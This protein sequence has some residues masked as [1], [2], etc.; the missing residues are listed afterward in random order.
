MRSNKAN[1][2][3]ALQQVI[4]HEI[5]IWY[6]SIAPGTVT[7]LADNRLLWMQGWIPIHWTVPRVKEIEYAEFIS[8]LFS[9]STDQNVYALDLLP[10]EVRILHFFILKTNLWPERKLIVVRALDLGVFDFFWETV[11]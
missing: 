9:E 8:T 3:N 7:S 5:C 4:V 1:C 11:P 10:T 2:P 6:N